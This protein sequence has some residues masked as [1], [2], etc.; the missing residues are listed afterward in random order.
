MVNQLLDDLNAPAAAKTELL[1]KLAGTCANFGLARLAARCRAL[2][3]VDTP[4]DDKQLAQLRDLYRHS[5][6][7]LG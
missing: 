6:E 2:E 5:L 3:K 7:A 1:H 4:V